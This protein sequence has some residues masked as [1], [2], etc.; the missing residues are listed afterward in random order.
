M[1]WQAM[2]HAAVSCKPAAQL[3][4]LCAVAPS[5]SRLVL[6]GAGGSWG[7]F[8]FPYWLEA[9]SCRARRSPWSASVSAQCLRHTQGSEDSD[10]YFAHVPAD[11]S[12]SKGL[13][14]IELVFATSHQPGMLVLGAPGDSWASSS[15]ITSPANG[16]PCHE[17][18]E[19]SGTT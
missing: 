7:P 5:P 8:P 3:T 1:Y 15:P 16:T 18:Y 4:W 11:T 2:V 14:V 13:P 9:R 19:K 10:R 17:Q 6:Q 12:L